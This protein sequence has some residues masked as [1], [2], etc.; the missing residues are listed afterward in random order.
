M[1][2]VLGTS[3]GSHTS[4]TGMEEVGVL[5]K[6]HFLNSVAD[7]VPFFSDPDPDSDPTY[8]DITKKNCYAI[9]Y[10]I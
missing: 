1:Q 10:L 7:P 9:S 5:V 6:Y 4:A 2:L 3:G 8:V